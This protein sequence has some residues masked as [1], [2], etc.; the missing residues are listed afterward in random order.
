ME[1]LVFGH[2]GARVIVF[3][4]RAGRFYDYENWKLVNALQHK[5]DQGHIQLY[6]LDSIDSESLYAY[7]KPP[8]ERIARHNQYE[9]YVLEE[10]LPLTRQLNSSPTL[11]AHGC[12]LGAYHA[13]NIAFRHPHL[14]QKVVALSGRYDL[15]TAIGSYEDRFDGHY[16]DA[17]YFHT[18]SHFIPQ[19]SDQWHLDSLRRMEIILAVGEEDVFVENNRHLSNALW[20][21]GVWHALHFWPGEAHRARPWRQMV[22]QYL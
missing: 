2:A 8:W 19:M 7:W 12:S 18:P 22:A 6:C 9:A 5:L 14:F 16:D 4:T 13:V 15:T 20:D 21:K 11:V 17:I 1:L 10:V 3:P